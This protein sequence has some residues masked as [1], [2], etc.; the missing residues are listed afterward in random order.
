MQSAEGARRGVGPLVLSPHRRR[1]TAPGRRTAS[2]P[3][4]AVTLLAMIG[5]TV[6][7][8]IRCAHQ[9]G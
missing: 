5:M 8:G 4:F 7:C 3:F 2:G 6:A 1:Q 9:Q